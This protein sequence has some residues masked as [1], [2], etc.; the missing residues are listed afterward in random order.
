MQ[1]ADSPNTPRRLQIDYDDHGECFAKYLPR[2]GSAVS[3]HTSSSGVG[4]WV[5]LCLDTPFEYQLRIGEPYQFRLARIE[6]FLIRSRWQGHNIGDL[7]DVSVFILLVEE[8]ERPAKAV[9]DSSEY[10]H[11]AWGMC[12]SVS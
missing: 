3:E 11:I 5:L 4:P 1:R 9:I 7:E 12:R 2:T 8:G 6:A 10:L